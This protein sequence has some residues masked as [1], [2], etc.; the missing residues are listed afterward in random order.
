MATNKKTAKK[1]AAKKATTKR[2]SKPIRARKLRDDANSEK[3]LD[4][5]AKKLGLPREAISFRT[6]TGRKMRSDASVESVRKHWD[7]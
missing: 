5:I 2:A 1:K 7:S 3:A 6:K 4:T